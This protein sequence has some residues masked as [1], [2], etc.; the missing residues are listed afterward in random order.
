MLLWNCKPMR[1]LVSGLL[2]IIVAVIV[3]EIMKYHTAAWLLGNL[4]TLLWMLGFAGYAVHD[5]RRTNRRL[6]ETIE[7]IRQIR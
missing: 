3:L 1:Y 5:L 2:V 7:H 6:D 4:G